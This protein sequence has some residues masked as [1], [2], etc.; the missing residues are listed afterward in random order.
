M[1]AGLS[2]PGWR[3][4]WGRVGSLAAGWRA[5]GEK[6]SRRDAVI[7]NQAEMSKDALTQGAGLRGR[8]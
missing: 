3:Q 1:L 8:D 7:Q 4:G 2:E 5:Q 6:D